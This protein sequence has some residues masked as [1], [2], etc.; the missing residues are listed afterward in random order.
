MCCCSLSVVRCSCA[1]ED[2]REAL[3][4]WD[5]KAKSDP[6]FFGKAYGESQPDAIFKESTAEDLANDEKLRKVSEVR[7]A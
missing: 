1:A 7:K 4:K 3:L 6:M 5:D 2:P